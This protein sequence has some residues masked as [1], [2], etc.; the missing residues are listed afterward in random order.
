MKDFTELTEGFQRRRLE[1]VH[2]ELETGATFAAV[3]QTERTLGN[4]ER[5][6]R[7]LRLAESA[8]R[9][10][11]RRLNECDPAEMQA[12]FDSAQSKLEALEATI[13]ELRR[14]RLES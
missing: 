3:A 11:K 1:F 6:A 12:S 14:F 13:A 5:A 9:E 7:N 4:T 8:C 10:A 2:T